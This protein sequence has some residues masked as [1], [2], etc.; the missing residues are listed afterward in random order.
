MDSRYFKAHETRCK[1]GCGQ[2]QM[3]PH[4]L[5]KLDGFREAVNRPL[6]ITSGYRCPKHNSKVSRTGKSGSHTTG[7][8]VDIQVRNSKERYELLR[9]AFFHGFTG[10]GI[11]EWFIHL[12]DLDISKRP[13]SWV[14]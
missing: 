8:A 6:T 13:N 2:N 7:R 10:I 5:A 4:F 14:Y 11:S 9:L 3:D 12:D 1:C